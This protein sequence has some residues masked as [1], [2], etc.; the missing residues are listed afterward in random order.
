VIESGERY[1]MM[2]TCVSTAFLDRH[3]SAP[4]DNSADLSSTRENSAESDFLIITEPEA[5]C[6]TVNSSDSR[7]NPDTKFSSDA[8]NRTEFE[9]SFDSEMP[10]D[11][12]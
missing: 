7:P 4:L 12:P 10:G 5:L 1:E 6:D 8:E 2:T 9:P 11:L 3:I